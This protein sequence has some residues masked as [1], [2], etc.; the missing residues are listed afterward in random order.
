[1]AN[2]SVSTAQDSS[3]Q[4]PE[5]WAIERALKLTGR[6]NGSFDAGYA[7]RC[8]KRQPS[9]NST[10][11]AFAAYI[12]AHEQPPVDPLYEALKAVVE[13]GRYDTREQTALLRGELK[14][15]GLQIIELGQERQP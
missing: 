1:M 13:L 15:R 12:Q 10:T 8:V 6:G 9:G 7:L 3:E 5:D 2:E 14:A 4:M 11:L